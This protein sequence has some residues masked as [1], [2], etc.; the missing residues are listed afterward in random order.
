MNTHVFSIH[1]HLYSV[2]EYVNVKMT[3]VI[4]YA[5]RFTVIGLQK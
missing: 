2:K 1:Y 5:P 3:T 4:V